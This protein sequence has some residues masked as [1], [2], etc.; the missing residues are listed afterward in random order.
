MT[1]ALTVDDLDWAVAV[2][3]RRRD[4]LATQAPIFWRPDTR[5]VQHHRLFLE[6]L[7]TSGGAFGYRTEHSVLIAAPRGEGWLIDDAH[8]PHERWL[9][10][11]GAALWAALAGDH[12]GEAVRFVCPTSEWERGAFARQHGL[13][14]A[15]SWWLRELPGSGG[16]EA[17]QPVELPGAAAVTVEAPPVYAPPGPILFL[18]AVTDAN[19]ALVA[20]SEQAPRLGCAAIVV[21]QPADD[22]GLPALLTQTGFHQHCDFYTGII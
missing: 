6:H 21:N 3:A 1:R 18:N 13:E 2:L 8:V 7:L 10:T 22:G 11:D 20:A 12:G 4:A 15:E 5:S 16:G 17:G 9:D 14:L 19:S